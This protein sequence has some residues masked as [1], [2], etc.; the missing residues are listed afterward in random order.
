MS[1]EDRLDQLINYYKTLHEVEVAV[2]HF[3]NS[4]N[5]E[6]CLIYAR[7]K[8]KQALKKANKGGK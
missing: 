4:N 2:R 1:I 3:S 8:W 5:L 7:N 6:S